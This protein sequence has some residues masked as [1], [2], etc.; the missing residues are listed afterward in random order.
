M[1]VF[2]KA[3]ELATIGFEYAI[4]VIK[5]GTKSCVF[6]SNLASALTEDLLESNFP[7]TV[8]SFRKP[9]REAAEEMNQAIATNKEKWAELKQNLRVSLADEVGDGEND[10]FTYNKGGERVIGNYFIR[11][12]VVGWEIAIDD[13][14]KIA[15]GIKLEGDIV[16]TTDTRGDAI[17]WAK[18]AYRLDAFCASL[19]V[20]MGVGYRWRRG[21]GTTVSFY[22]TKPLLA[23]AVEADLVVCIDENDHLGIVYSDPAITD[24]I[25]EEDDDLLCDILLDIAL[26]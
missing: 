10:P 21:K 20:R 14:D 23:S 1:N 26:V 9:I 13:P 7:E 6:S 8:K 16:F 4:S 17:D 22:N 19:Q 5:L 11:K 2:D 3:A 24:V 15:E 25:T 12:G 18:T